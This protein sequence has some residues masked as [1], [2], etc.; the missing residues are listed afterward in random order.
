[1]HPGRAHTSVTV[2]ADLRLSRLRKRL[3]MD[4]AMTQSASRSNNRV[5]VSCTIVPDIMVTNRATMQRLIDL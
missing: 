4:E 1:M 5:H 3:P 2:F